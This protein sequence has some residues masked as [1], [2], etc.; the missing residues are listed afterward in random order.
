MSFGAVASPDSDGGGWSCGGFLSLTACGMREVGAE[1]EMAA[2]GGRRMNYVG[3]GERFVGLTSPTDKA[4]PHVSSRRDDARL[5]VRRYV[6]TGILLP[7]PLCNHVNPKINV[8]NT[9]K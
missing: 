7:D 8:D 6:R 4:D 5:F 9:A 1:N 2:V 3:G